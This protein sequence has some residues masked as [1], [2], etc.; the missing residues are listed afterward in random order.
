MLENTKH[1]TYLIT[2]DHYT[3]LSGAL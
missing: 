2:H 1:L 3:S